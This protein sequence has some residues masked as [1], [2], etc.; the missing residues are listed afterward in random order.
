M[1]WFVLLGGLA[2]VFFIFGWQALI[3]GILLGV[4][5]AIWLIRR[6]VSKQKSTDPNGLPRPS[7]GE[8][9]PVDLSEWYIEENERGNRFMIDDALDLPGVSSEQ[10][11]L[12][13]TEDLM[14]RGF[15]K[16]QY[17]LSW[18]QKIVN[19]PEFL[20]SPEGIE[21]TNSMGGVA[22]D[23]LD[24]HVQGWKTNDFRK[25]GLELLLS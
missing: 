13:I 6:D 4:L 17:M 7:G 1:V 15:K 5:G 25:I 20:A 8:P 19:D 18:R 2:I 9:A 16:N 10:E 22:F 23:F 3:P 21:A 24:E 11:R 14:S 12:A